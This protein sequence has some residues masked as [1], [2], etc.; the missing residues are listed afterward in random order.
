MNSVCRLPDMRPSYHV[1]EATPANTG[2]SAYCLRT[3]V[4]ETGLDVRS[5][6]ASACMNL[7]REQASLNSGASHASSG[8]CLSTSRTSDASLF[9]WMCSA[10]K[11]PQ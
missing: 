1:R 11:R 8:R 3:P 7:S 10:R 4:C 6:E 9:L 2:A 5:F